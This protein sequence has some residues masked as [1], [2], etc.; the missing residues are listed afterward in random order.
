MK[1][2]PIL[3][4]LILPLLVRA[5][6]EPVPP[7]NLDLYLLAGQSNMAGRGTVEAT[8]RQ[9]HPRIWV[10]NADG[11]WVPATEPLHF[12][13]PSVVGVGPGLSFA[14]AMA[15]A[16]PSV[17]IGLIPAAVGG[18]PMAAWQP[19]GFHEQTKTH[20]YDDA[21]RRLQ[22]ARSAG[23]LKGILWHQGES[24][25]KLELAA[26]Y[27]EKLTQ[28][29]DR[30]RREVGAEVPVV[31]GSLGDFYVAKHAAAETINS[32]LKSIP[33]RVSGTACVDATGLTDR[34]DQTHFDAASARELGRRYAEAL[35]KLQR[36]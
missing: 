3:T 13:K 27:A 12:D 28:L 11:K 24:D 16:D 29:I 21:L 34:G 22:A 14:R 35:R 36:K 26:I 18:S 6:P 15:E 2:F 7:K 31:V 9:V 19:G 17:N 8:D 4:L 33:Q 32:V 30:F 1:I 23:T 5:Q 10:L 20:P 25:S